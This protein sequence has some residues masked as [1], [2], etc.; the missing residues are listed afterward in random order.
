VLGAFVAVGGEDDF[1]GSGDDSSETTGTVI[2][3]VG[4]LGLASAVI[5]DASYFGFEERPRRGQSRATLTP[6]LDPQH[7]RFGLGYVSSF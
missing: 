6:W 1:I 5:L 7:G 2:A 4:M 3:V